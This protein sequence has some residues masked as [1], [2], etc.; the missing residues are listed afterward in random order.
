MYIE[1][2]ES[3]AVNPVICPFVDF[4]LNTWTAEELDFYTDVSKAENL[5]MGGVFNQ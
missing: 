1:G 2:P 3:K 4:K 5:G